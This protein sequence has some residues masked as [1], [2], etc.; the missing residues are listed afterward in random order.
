VSH[1]SFVIAAYLVAGAGTLAVL[2]E[3]YLS[4]RR[5]EGRAERLRRDR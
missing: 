1:W 4:M 2:I 3:S 5:A